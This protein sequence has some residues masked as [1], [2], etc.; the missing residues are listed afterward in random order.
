MVYHAVA[1]DFRSIN[2]YS[3][4][5]PPYYEALRT[6][7][8]DADETLLAPFVDRGDVHVLVGRNETR[9]RALVA[10]QP[11]ARVVSDDALVH[12]RL[13][14]RPMPPVR[15]T[16]G[17]RRVLIHGVGSSCSPERAALIA[18]GTVGSG[19]TCGGK[20]PDQTV[21]VDLGQS[22]TVGAI[23]HAMGASATFFP[24][25]LVVE[26]SLDGTS[27]TAAWEGSP[28]AGALQAAMASPRDARIVVEFP[29]REARYLRLRQLIRGKDYIW[30]IAELEVW[31]GS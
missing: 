29:Q 11:G 4:Y 18:D 14:R 6:L 7:S 12:Y 23:V 19:W 8:E 30:L 9:L 16:P 22:A 5:Q 31:S 3:G 17:G 27:W 25:H 1:D 10:R 21:I 28:A 20:A 15:T 13:A 26:S 24:R 2:G